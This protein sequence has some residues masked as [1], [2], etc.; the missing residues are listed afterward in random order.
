M[1][2]E[3]AS[4]GAVPPSADQEDIDTVIEEVAKDAEAESD[5]IVAEE[6][7]KGYLK[8]GDGL[9]VHLPGTAGTRALAEGEVFDDEALATAWLQ[10]VDEP[11]PS[12]GGSQEEQL[13]RAMGANFQKLQALHLARLD[14]AKS[15]LAAV[16]K[17]EAD[18]EERVAQTQ[19]WFCEAQE[20]LKAAQ[21]ELAER[22]RELI[23]KQ[24]DVEKAQEHQALLDSQE[25][26]LTAREEALAATLRGKDKEVEKLVA[27]GTQE[28]EQRHKDT[29]DAL[30]LDH[31]GKVKELE[32]ERD[33]LNKKVLELM[34][35][36]DTAN[37]ALADAQAAVLVKAELLS[38]ANDSINDLKLKLDGLEGTL[39]EVRARE[40]T[41]TKDLEEEKRLRRDGTAEYEEYAK[42]VNLWIGRLVDVAGKLTAQLAVM[43]M[44]DVRLFEDRNISPN[45]RLTLF[46]ERI[47]D[48]LDQL[49]SNRATY[50]ANEA[51]RLCRGALTKVAF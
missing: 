30:T 13:L 9:F 39:S 18:L 16:D 46:F 35:E 22:K 15:K 25:E 21:D 41:L 7:A 1:E 11:S 38:K 36:K 51:R 12:D 28:L 44:P 26:D 47:L 42:G 17:A 8:V 32:L 27:Q 19:A 40:E 50:L 4:L 48:A 24:A 3:G 49:R 29:L 14:K 23:L 2:E 33:G 37:G 10:V 34:E 6:A 43:G 5:K 45:A 31:A 20:G